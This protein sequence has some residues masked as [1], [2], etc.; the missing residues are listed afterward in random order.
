MTGA[1]PAG[2]RPLSAVDRARLRAAARHA[3]AALPGP[4]AAAVAEQLRS[5]ESVGHRFGS[6]GLMARVVDAVLGL[7]V[8][9]QGLQEP[10]PAPGDSAA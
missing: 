8:L 5:W 7:P 1:A 2:A 10:L 4:V 6:H 3:V 9:E